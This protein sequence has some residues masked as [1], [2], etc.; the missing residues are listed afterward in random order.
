MRARLEVAKGV[1]P[2]RIKVA[3]EAGE[4][5]FVA[6]GTPPFPANPHDLGNGAGGAVRPLPLPL[7]TVP[8]A[9]SYLFLFPP[10]TGL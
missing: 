8:A 7:S 4:T 3:G 10:V 9:A 6:S 5:A 1:R 2:A